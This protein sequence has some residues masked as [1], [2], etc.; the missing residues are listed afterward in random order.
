MLCFD[1][2]QMSSEVTSII[3]IGSFH[4]HVNPIPS[5]KFFTSYW[6]CPSIS[7]ITVS[8]LPEDEPVEVVIP[9]VEESETVP[10][11]TE[12]IITT[13]EEE[14]IVPEEELAQGSL[15]CDARRTIALLQV[16]PIERGVCR[17]ERGAAGCE[18]NN[19]DEK[20]NENLLREHDSPHLVYVRS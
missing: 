8:D 16:D 7:H 9:D 4:S 10:V 6:F 14:D 15:L 11:E 13:I 3:S 12:P 1:F 19:R 17:P 18:Q 2:L 5:L 20:G